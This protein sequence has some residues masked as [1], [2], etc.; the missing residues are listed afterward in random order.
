MPD[1]LALPSVRQQRARPWLR[2]A[3]RPRTTN[4]VVPPGEQP[5]LQLAI[6][7]GMILL[8]RRTRQ[9]GWISYPVDPTALAQVLGQLPM[10]SGLLPAETIGYGLRNGTPFFVQYVPP[11]QLHLHTEQQVYRWPTP[12]LLWSG[13]GTTYHLCALQHV[14]QPGPE[15]GQEVVCS[16]PFPNT[17]A[18]G[19]ICWG[20]V[21][22]TPATAQ[23]MGTMLETFLEGSLFNLHIAAQKSRRFAASILS[24]YRWLEAE[25][26]ET[27][28]R[29][30]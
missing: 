25:Q 1:E 12:P 21:P 7:P 9:Q 27:I 11:R 28:P 17:Y 5:L 23:S 13:C 2:R 8:T 26:V 24:M 29:T 6:Y 15:R 4:V 22:I 16:A 30:I 19:T 18:N 3:M 20:N 14:G 10:A